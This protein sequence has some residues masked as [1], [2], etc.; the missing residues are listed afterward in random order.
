MGIPFGILT[1]SLCDRYQCHRS[2]YLA[3]LILSLLCYSLLTIPILF[4][5]HSP[6]LSIEDGKEEE[7]PNRWFYL[8]AICVILASMLLT[9]QLNMGE[10]FCSNYANRSGR[11]YGSFR[12]WGGVGFVVTFL[13]LYMIDP[14]TKSLPPLLPHL[15]ILNAMT[16]LI[17]VALQFWPDQSGLKLSDIEDPTQRM[18]RSIF[19][20]QGLKSKRVLSSNQ[21]DMRLTS[22]MS[23]PSIVVTK[24]HLTLSFDAESIIQPEKLTR[25]SLTPVQDSYWVYSA[26]LGQE[27]SKHFTHLT[28]VTPL[29]DRNQ[30]Q[31]DAIR[32]IKLDQVEPANQRQ[33]NELSFLLSMRLFGSFIRRDPLLARFLLMYFLCGMAEASNNFYFV[34]FMR[35]LDPD[36]ALGLSA[37]VFAASY[38]AETL[39]YKISDRV[40]SYLSSSKVL[41]LV[42]LT[43]G[44]RYSLYLPFLAG[45]TTSL[46]FL[47]LVETLR[48]ITTGLFNCIFYV[49]AIDFSMRGANMASEFLGMFKDNNSEELLAN[50]IKFTMM[51][52][53]SCFYDGLG[54]GLGPLI[55]GFILDRYEFY[56]LWA[57]IASVMYLSSLVNTIIDF[58]NGHP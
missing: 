45:K 18:A 8:V 40:M 50:K 36:E 37:L 33:V 15:I 48:A 53:S 46:K 21:S 26:G 17:L 55:G 29:R 34:E 1:G 12:F 2:G 39:S 7:K 14:V 6:E 51:I 27:T 44:I 25:F 24:A 20:F 16:L 42:A 28:K 41:S 22:I 57:S 3:S 10:T 13:F 47:V 23:D 58:K 56:G 43:Y 31:A 54:F 11:S 32:E 35:Y 5:D 9:F 49:L 19:E 4:K 52:I 30:I 38:A